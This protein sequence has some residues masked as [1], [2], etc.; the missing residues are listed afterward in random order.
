MAQAAL[1]AGPVELEI[2]ADAGTYTLGLGAGGSVRPLATGLTRY[3][4][5]EVAGGFTGAYFAMYAT[6]QGQPCAAAADFDW[7]EYEGA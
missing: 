5:S 7:F 2:R 6:G 4:S 1:P 3:L